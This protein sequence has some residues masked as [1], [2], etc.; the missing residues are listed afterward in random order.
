MNTKMIW[1]A[2]FI[3]IYILISIYFTWIVIKSELDRQR[4]A[5][6]I[7]FIWII[8]II[9][10]ILIKTILKPISKKDMRINKTNYYESGIGINAESPHS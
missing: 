10:G 8:P 1:I 9:W 6:K 5:L 4:K 7:I 3:L 2:I